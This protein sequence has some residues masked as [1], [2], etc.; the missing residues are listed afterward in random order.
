[1]SAFAALVLRHRTNLVTEKR[2]MAE[3][4]RLEYNNWQIQQIGAVAFAFRNWPT[5][6]KAARWRDA[7]V[8]RAKVNGERW[9]HWRDEVEQ[10][11]AYFGE[12]EALTFD[13]GLRCEWAKHVLHD[14]LMTYLIALDAWP[15]TRHDILASSEPGLR[16][17]AEYTKTHKE[18][19]LYLFDVEQI[20][21]RTPRTVIRLWASWDAVDGDRQATDDMILQEARRQQDEIRAELAQQDFLVI[22]TEPALDRHIHWLYLRIC[23]QPDIG[24]P[25][26]ADMIAKREDPSRRT[27][28]DA[29]RSLARELGLTLLPLPPGK[30]RRS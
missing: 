5:F 11:G 7:I 29:I 12:L 15:A 8:F 21:L 4:E 25:W 24:R 19:T 28:R 9:H 13:W 10:L 3:Y 30:P 23:P 27:V 1:M 26:G 17:L 18:L 20:R 6:W 2:F 16:K 22:D 14:S